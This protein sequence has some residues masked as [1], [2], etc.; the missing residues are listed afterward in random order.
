M[1]RVKYFGAAALLTLLAACGNDDM[2][3]ASYQDDPLAV[4]ITATAGKNVITRSN[5]MDDANQSAF[6]DGDQIS[7]GTDDQDTVIYRKEGAGWNPGS[8]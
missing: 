8:T 3:N 7:V 6:K 4:R 2:E 1:K 5:P